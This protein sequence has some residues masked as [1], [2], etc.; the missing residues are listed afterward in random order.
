MLSCIFVLLLL[1]I[2]FRLYFYIAYHQFHTTI[3]TQGSP[4]QVSDSI[5]GFKNTPY[6]LDYN[7]NYQN[8]EEGFKSF[9][10]DISIP[11]KKAND[12]WV[13]LLGGS[14]MEGMGSNKDGEWLDITGVGDHPASESIA[15]KL[16][17]LLQAKLP[18]KN[19]KVFN[20]AASSYI[21]WQSMQKYIQLRKKMAVDWVISM[22]G[23]NEIPSI[24]ENFDI[25]MS[26]QEDWQQRPIFKAPSKYIIPVTQ[27]SF[28]LNSLKQSI[29]D[30]KYNVRMTN[31][32]KSNFPACT[33]WLNKAPLPIKLAAEDKGINRAIGF[34][35]KTLNEFDSLL[36]QSHT[37]HLLVFQPFLFDKEYQLMDSVEKALYS[38]YTWNYNDAT[39]NRFIKELKEILLE[40]EKVDEQFLV[41]KPGNIKTGLFVDYCHFTRSGIDSISGIFASVILK[42]L[43]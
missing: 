43:K 31:N 11:E 32:R 3:Y 22:D 37:K 34:Y 42:S 35:M 25:K 7:R 30:I 24:G 38:Y 29:Y 15:Y 39:R 27:H 14:A 40:K 19:V 23:N 1:E 20:A 12:F 13:L 33:Y 2:I 10:G 8:N 26:I 21:F 41:I 4:L 28:F 17:L 18:G 9:P 6:Y 5:T 36:T 16:Q